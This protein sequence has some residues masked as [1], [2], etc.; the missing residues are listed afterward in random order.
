MRHL[1]STS[2]PIDDLMESSLDTLKTLRKVKMDKL[3][4]CKVKE[5]GFFDKLWRKNLKIPDTPKSSLKRTVSSVSKG[6]SRT[7]EKPRQ[8]ENGKRRSRSA[9][10]TK[11]EQ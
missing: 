2:L 10:H 11:K 9:S 6:R 5:K 4:D 1:A 3:D 7:D 8:E